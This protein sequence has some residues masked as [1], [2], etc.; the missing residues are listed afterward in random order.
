MFTQ[1]IETL[2]QELSTLQA[3]LAEDNTFN[4]MFSIYER[5]SD[6]IHAG[7]QELRVQDQ[8][9]HILC[10]DAEGEVVRDPEGHIVLK[11]FTTALSK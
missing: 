10:V 8:Q 3:M 7:I 2:I 5:M 1:D 4:D 6:L 9:C 11:T